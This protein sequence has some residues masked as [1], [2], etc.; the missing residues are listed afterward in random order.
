MNVVNIYFW[1]ILTNSSWFKADL[2]WVSLFYS[3]KASKS[4]CKYQHFNFYKTLISQYKSSSSSCWRSPKILCSVWM[5]ITQLISETMI[6]LVSVLFMRINW[7]ISF[8][9]SAL[10]S[11]IILILNKPA[12]SK[13]NG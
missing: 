10:L 3:N 8:Q 11:S 9:W 4:E 5:N 1:F 12:N 7:L 13:T 2:K 6:Y